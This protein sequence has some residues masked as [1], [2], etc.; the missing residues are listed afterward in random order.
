MKHDLTNALYEKNMLKKNEVVSE[1]DLN[2]IGNEILS[3]L[4]NLKGDLESREEGI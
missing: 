2:K 3:A 4:V 1:M